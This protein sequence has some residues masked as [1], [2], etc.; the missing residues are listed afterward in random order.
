MST[1]AT[2]SPA[3][4]TSTGPPPILPTYRTRRSEHRY[5]DGKLYGA[6]IAAK[7]G[8]RPSRWQQYVLDVGL[9]RVDGPGSP[10]AYANVDL[11]VGRRCGKS[12]T[13]MGVPLARSLQGPITLDNGRVLPFLG[14][15]TAQN[16]V[17][18][19]QRFMKDLVEPY[20]ESM[21]PTVWRAGVKL[22]EAIGDTSLTI[23]AATIGKDWRNPRASTIQVFAP[24]RS[25]VRGD[26]IAHLTFDEYLVFSAVAGQEL[27]AAA[28][29]TLGDARGH[30]Q[31]WRCSN[32]SLLNNDQTALWEMMT[33][34][35]GIVESGATTGT[36]Y[37]EFT[38]DDGFDLDDE[39]TWPLYYPA[40]A[41][42]IIRMEELRADRIRLGD[43][44]FAAEYFGVWPGAGHTVK[45]WTVVSRTS[46]DAAGVDADKLQL[47]DTAAGIG[48]DIDP[49]D[50]GASITACTADPDKDGLLE[51]VI[52]DRQGVAWLAGRLRELAPG[53]AAIA[54]DDYGAGHDL[55]VQLQDDKLV[56]PKLIA[57]K[58]QDLIAACF[59]WDARLR[60]GGLRVRRSDYYAT[61]QAEIAA[62]QRTSGRG[63]Q[64]ERRGPIPAKT[65]MASTLAAWAY[66]HQPAQVADSQIW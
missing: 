39:R 18:A 24:T 7:L 59:S 60:A 30:G 45:L 58:S 37:F 50:R 21:S 27:M 4:S 40:I 1:R 28:G 2:G 41:D 34:G 31:I 54:V 42:N 63:W 46:W 44:S 61:M 23:D 32:V 25:S 20:R 35:R 9:E 17:K 64:Y 56:G 15:H 57:V 47:P 55:V 62:V 48:V 13:T 43:E 12:V 22:R 33:A 66:Q 29:P 53:V 11:I 51:E 16:L 38:V 5:S 52:D 10:F 8:R 14:A 65:V 36:A 3:S 6:I 19:R 26:G 49:Y